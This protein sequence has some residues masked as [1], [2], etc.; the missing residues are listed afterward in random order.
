MTHQK[1]CHLLRVPHA[2]TKSLGH[3]A[4]VPEEVRSWED[5]WVVMVLLLRLVLELR[6]GPVLHERRRKADTARQG[7]AENCDR[8]AAVERSSARW[9]NIPAAAVVMVV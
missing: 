8:R 6:V 9:R 3:D 2:L 5:V 7:R 1:R 4:V